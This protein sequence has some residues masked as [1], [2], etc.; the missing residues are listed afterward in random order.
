M[1]VQGIVSS[2]AGS[3]E[4]DQRIT[5]W[6]VTCSG[7]PLI[8]Q[9]SSG[10][11]VLQESQSR[12][13]LNRRNKAARCQ[14]ND[15]KSSVGFS[16]LI[17]VGS[18]AATSAN[19]TNRI[20]KVDKPGK[21]ISRKVKNK[22]KNHKRPSSLCNILPEE[23]VRCNSCFQ[24]SDNVHTGNTA[25]NTMTSD[26][27]SLVEKFHD[28]TGNEVANSSSTPTSCISFNDVTDELEMSESIHQDFT[29]ENNKWDQSR[30]DET[31]AGLGNSSSLFHTNASDNKDAEP[32]Q[33]Q[34]NSIVN[35]SSGNDVFNSFSD[36]WNSDATNN[37]SISVEASPF[38][39]ERAGK[40]SLDSGIA[41]DY[42]S[43]STSL[44]SSLAANQY[45]PQE[46]SDCLPMEPSSRDWPIITGSTTCVD[47][48]RT[49]SQ[50]CSSTNT[51]SAL[52][53]KRRTKKLLGSTRKVGNQTGNVNVHGRTGKENNH[54]VWRKVR[55]NG[56]FICKAMCKSP[57][58]SMDEA[59]LSMICDTLMDQ[60][61][62]DMD[63]PSLDEMPAE[64]DGLEGNLAVFNSVS[65]SMKADGESLQVNVSKFKKSPGFSRK[66]EHKSNPRKGHHSSKTNSTNPARKIVKQKESFESFDQIAGVSSPENAASGSTVSQNS[67]VYLV[68]KK[69]PAYV[70]NAIPNTYT[71][72]SQNFA[73]DCV[74][75][76]VLPGMKSD[77]SSHLSHD[78]ECQGLSVLG[79]E[80]QHSDCGKQ[81]HGSCSFLQRWVPV[82]RKDSV[83][84]NRSNADTMVTSHLAEPAADGLDVKDQEIGNFCS[85]VTLKVERGNPNTLPICQ[86]STEEGG[87]KAGESRYQT[88]SHSSPCSL[89]TESKDR[90]IQIETDTEKILQ[91]V[92]D[93]YH[94]QLECERIQ[95]VIGGPL[96]EFERVIYSASPVV[97]HVPI[98]RH[99]S[100]C[101]ADQVAGDSL[102]M[103]RLPN[104]CLASLWEWYE[105]HGSYGLEVKAVD[106]QHSRRLG[107]HHFEFCAYFVPFLSAVQ[108]FGTRRGICNAKVS[109]SCAVDTTEKDSPKP[110]FLPILSMLVPQP[111]NPSSV[112]STTGFSHSDSSS[113]CRCGALCGESELL[114]EYF[115][116]EQ[117]QQRRPLF[118]KIKELVRGEATL[119]CRIFGDPKN[120]ESL[121][122]HDLHPSSWYSVAWYP[123]YRIPD[124]NFRAAFLTYHSL[125]H[126]IHRDTQN[127]LNEETGVV[128]PVVGLQSYNAQGECW[129]RPLNLSAS[130]AADQTDSL[131]PSNILKERLRTLEQTASVM[132]RAA[133]RMGNQKLLNRQ[134]DY[135]FF[136]SRRR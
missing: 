85:L 108:L 114:F 104:I 55:K 47:R 68:D 86:P 1:D 23:D 15:N 102:C 43:Y 117:P 2:P 59:P 42:C 77:C 44:D 84:T 125:G 116:S 9:S 87:G 81:A 4:A 95:M 119:N 82:G 92:D 33:K 17:W 113:G 130:A 132:A 66:Q 118:E 105:R 35:I 135:E 19:C 69:L 38:L 100:T 20:S 128:T 73:P 61:G 65:S 98:R 80:D 75:K 134:P 31:S 123:I 112:P 103:H 111:C 22:G 94:T 12:G 72:F 49:G 124:G 93:S 60:T 36:G 53:G 110:S 63:S 34:N 126:F 45:F 131:M 67:A 97:S 54:S 10:V 79:P 64:Q 121:H 106:F 101:S 109:E 46:T 90:E 28:D 25:T 51:Y 48:T 27:S 18:D 39:K 107:A 26:L 5:H 14:N 6:K 136:L 89:T 40:F 32:P 129:F 83:A 96:A 56:E 52:S 30:I 120:L 50:E 78:N 74:D 91:V 122:L 41:S 88:P 57:V 133:V 58:V 21:K 13:P 76:K 29:A 62:S 24:T 7:K 8:L 71:E 16:G 127:C 37:D 3:F 70:H 115:E 11:N 99:C